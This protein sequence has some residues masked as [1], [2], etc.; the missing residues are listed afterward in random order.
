MDTFRVMVLG[1]SGSGKTVMLASM[2]TRLCV[3]H[4]DIGFYFEVP[5][6]TKKSSW[7]T[8]TIFPTPK[9]AGRREPLA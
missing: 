8:T 7:L 6:D 1:G 3:Q 5:E 4:K 2:Y 9:R